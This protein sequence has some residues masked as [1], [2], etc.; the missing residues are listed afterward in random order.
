M[1]ATIRM[2]RE[3]LILFLKSLPPKSQFQVIS[4]GSN[5]KWIDN[6]AKLK[7]TEVDVVNKAVD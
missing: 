5:F 3:A 2:A 7:Q 4:F 6:Q 1:Y